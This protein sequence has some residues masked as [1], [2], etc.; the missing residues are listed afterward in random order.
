MHCPKLRYAENNP[1]KKK[2]NTSSDICLENVF[3]E[4]L[5]QKLWSFLFFFIVDKALSVQKIS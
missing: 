5:L 2:K 1:K 4:V 3:I